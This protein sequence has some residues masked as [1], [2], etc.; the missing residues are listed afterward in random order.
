M[1]PCRVPVQS[2]RSVHVPTA[3]VRDV[4]PAPWSVV[5]ISPAVANYLSLRSQRLELQ[6]SASVLS[7]QTGWIAAIRVFNSPVFYVYSGHWH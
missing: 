7:V 1:V 2:L 4:S 3:V 6:A 5:D